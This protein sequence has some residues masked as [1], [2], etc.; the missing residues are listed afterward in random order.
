[1]PSMQE[2]IIPI[3]TTTIWINKFREEEQQ[4]HQQQEEHCSEEARALRAAKG[5]VGGK[6]KSVEDG[7]ANPVKV[8]GANLLQH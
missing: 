4:E 3:T 2:P 6:S 1:M 8:G 5:K 7:K